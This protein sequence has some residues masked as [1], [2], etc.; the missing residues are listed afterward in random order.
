MT[1]ERATDEA[2]VI[3]PDGRI[4]DLPRQHT[5][6]S[7]SELTRVIG[8]PFQTVDLDGRAGLVLVYSPDEGGDRRVNH[9][10]T[11]LLGSRLVTGPAVV[12]AKRLVP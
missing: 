7:K 4:H 1:Q 10:A 2:F 5:L 8:G 9:R 6:P 12:M 3:E 11:S